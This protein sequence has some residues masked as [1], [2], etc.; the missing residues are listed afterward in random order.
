MIESAM[1]Q[2][3][4]DT[5]PCALLMQVCHPDRLV[6]DN[7]RSSALKH[8]AGVL[9]DVLRK[10]YGNFKQS[11][12]AFGDL[13]ASPDMRNLGAFSPQSSLIRR[14]AFSRYD[15]NDSRFMD[16]NDASNPF[17][18]EELNPFQD[19]GDRDPGLHA[20]EFTSKFSPGVFDDSDQEENPFAC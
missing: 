7:V 19:D 13:G 12:D 6:R 9:F 15:D 5:Y 4:P 10:A 18:D 16:G 3:L 8:H 11:L 1:V 20:S 17:A 2:T 14:Q